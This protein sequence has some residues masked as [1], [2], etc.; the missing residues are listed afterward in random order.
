MAE[1]PRIKAAQKI[2]EYTKQ[3]KV[4]EFKGRDILTNKRCFKLYS[5]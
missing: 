1:N 3:S 2:L 5:E 4:K